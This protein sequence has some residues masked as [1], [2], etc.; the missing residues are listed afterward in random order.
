MSVS[1]IVG[2]GLT[3]FLLGLVADIWR[4]QHGFIMLGLMNLAAV[5]LAV[6]LMPLLRKADRTAPLPKP[7]FPGTAL[8]T[9]K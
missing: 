5:V 2:C 3:P 9:E 7:L 1:T 8:D 6:K 4:F